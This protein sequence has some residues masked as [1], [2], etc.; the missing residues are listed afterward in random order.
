MWKKLPNA[1]KISIRQMFTP[2]HLSLKMRTFLSV[3]PS[4]PVSSALYSI[5]HHHQKTTPQKFHL[6][7]NLK[8]HASLRI[9]MH[10]YDEKK[11]VK[12]RK[13][14]KKTYYY[15]TKNF[16]HEKKNLP[17]NLFFGSFCIWWVFSLSL[18][19]LSSLTIKMLSKFLHVTLKKKLKINEKIVARIFPK[20][21]Y[22]F[23]LSR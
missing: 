3:D 13:I 15:Y 7:E 8:E 11:I 21:P 18:S 1:H 12:Y 9:T 22:D 6:K 20:K 2:P 17:K 10:K 5:P 23:R 16:L 4:T 19:L 14:Q